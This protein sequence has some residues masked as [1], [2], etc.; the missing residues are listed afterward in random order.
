MGTITAD[1]NY[2]VDTGMPAVLYVGWPQMEQEAIPPRYEQRTMTVRDGRRLR[3][4]FEL[5]LHGFVFVDH[6][7][8]V[9]DFRNGAERTHVYDREV[10]TLVKMVSGARDV[11]VFDHTIRIG[12]QHVPGHMDQRA[13]VRRVH[14]DYTDV[15]ALRRLHA[16]VGDAN[17]ARLCK[18]RW[19][20][21]QVWRPIRD[22]VLVD[23]LGI[24][25]ARSV[26]RSSFIRVERRY[27]DR[28][29][30]NYQVAHDRAHRWFYFPQM[31]RHEA[32]VFKVF[33]SDLGR[34]SRF[35]A[36]SAFHDPLT[37]ADAH[38]RE[39]IETRAFAFFD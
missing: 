16:I 14:N 22:R 8:C 37:P 2:I 23:P 17:A 13:P 1:F 12:G 19:A 7:T 39:S 15:S 26:C 27:K 24:C 38:P 29:G 36:H 10:R 33:D 25:D 21:V 31:E 32:L 4:T 18:K 30:E 9:Q 11:L 6:S 5:E 34:T 3:H 20:I 28:T 35:T